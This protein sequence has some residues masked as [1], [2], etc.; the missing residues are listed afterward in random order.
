MIESG[1]YDKR[2]IAISSVIVDLLSNLP[3]NVGAVMIFIGVAREVGKDDKKVTRLEMESYDE[4]ADLAIKK[5][6]DEIKDRYG[7]S[8]ARIY[9][10]RGSF[11]IGEPLVF[12]IMAGKSREQTFPALKEA[13]ERYKKEPAMWKKEVYVDESW[14]WISD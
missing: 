8:L 14:A 1:L 6:S 7:L 3:R 4:L 11:D 5:I 10:F 9:H 13:I 12:V 2:E